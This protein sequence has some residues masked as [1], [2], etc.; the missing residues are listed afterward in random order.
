[1]V[2]GCLHEF[3]CAVPLDAALWAHV[4][5]EHHVVAAI[6]DPP[7]PVANAVRMLLHV[8]SDIG[9]HH[10]NTRADV[11]YITLKDV[12]V[13]LLWHIAIYSA[14]PP[15]HPLIPPFPTALN[16]RSALNVARDLATIASAHT[17]RRAVSQ[18]QP[19]L[20]VASRNAYAN[21]QQLSLLGHIAFR[22]ASVLPTALRLS[23]DNQVLVVH[24]LVKTKGPWILADQ[25]MTEAAIRTSLQ[26]DLV[27][28]AAPS[29]E[30]S[31]AIRVGQAAARLTGTM[32]DLHD[33]GR[34]SL[35]LR[36]RLEAAERIRRQARNL[37]RPK[38]IV[39]F[40]GPIPDP[41]TLQQ[42]PSWY[43]LARTATTDKKKIA[44]DV[45]GQILSQVNDPPPP[46]LP[47]LSNVVNIIVIVERTSDWDI[48]L[49]ERRMYTRSVDPASSTFLGP[50]DVI[51]A[52]NLDRITRR[53]ADLPLLFRQ[54]PNLWVQGLRRTGSSGDYLVV[55]EDDVPTSQGGDDQGRFSEDDDVEEGEATWVQP[56]VDP[57]SNRHVIIRSHLTIEHRF[58][59][60]S[61]DYMRRW[62]DQDHPDMRAALSS[63]MN[64]HGL[65]ACY[66]YRRVSEGERDQN[67]AFNTSLE[68]QVTFISR[69]APEGYRIKSLAYVSISRDGTAVID[70]L[71][72]MRDALVIVTSVDRLARNPQ[73]MLQVRT[74]AR[75]RN[76]HLV[77]LV[78][79]ASA[80]QDISATSNL[81]LTAAPLRAKFACLVPVATQAKSLPCCWPTIVAGPTVHPDIV[82]VIERRIVAAQNF[83]S[84]FRISGFRGDPLLLLAPDF[85]ARNAQRGM[86]MPVQAALK[87][88]IATRG[89][90]RQQNTIQVEVFEGD[91]ASHCQ[92]MVNMC[93]SECRCNCRIKCAPSYRAVCMRSGGCPTLCPCTDHAHT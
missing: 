42:V 5:A 51:S 15:A 41:A 45:A 39:P 81:L 36:L 18:N 29:L 93:D 32:E 78:F 59:R 8:T 72:Q 37:Q 89:R 86:T 24:D 22:C 90:G 46:I 43:I 31:P 76:L 17:I 38:P 49:T 26:P 66:A 25:T 58:H 82:Q 14:P 61:H 70:V 85:T 50:S 91:N 60:Q 87:R 35:G 55:D 23:S 27:A 11:N 4:L 54:W 77:A 16:R 73:A 19:Q 6:R 3:T 83:I 52:V 56:H 69:F 71:N 21:F 63:Y 12:A 57:R 74:V 10:H 9:Q 20:L 92:C 62:I 7:Q 40:I 30:L 75:E 47:D 2:P 33:N 28:T 48:A 79:P 68:R 34:F 13:P 64:T 67:N 1:M 80:I 53:V 65:A 84:G 44:E 88:D